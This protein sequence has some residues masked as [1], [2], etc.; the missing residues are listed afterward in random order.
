[1]PPSFKSKHPPPEPS[2]WITSALIEETTGVGVDE[3]NCLDDLEILFAPLNQAAP[4]ANDHSNGHTVGLA[5]CAR[6]RRLSLVD[7]G[8]VKLGCLQPIAH[9][10]ERLCVADQ[11]LTSL[12]DL[13]SL[14]QLRWL[15]AQQNNITRIEGLDECPRL[16]ALW[17]FDNSIQRCEG[18][19]ELAELRELWLQNNKMKRL[20]GLEALTALRDLQLA[21]NPISDYRD[22]PRLARLPS[23]ESVGFRDAHFGSCPIAEREG[24]R[25]AVLGALRHVT[26]LDASEVT[27]QDRHRARDAHLE[28]V[29]EFHEKVDALQREHRDDAAAIEARRRRSS[30]HARSLDGEMR[31]AF[32]ELERLVDEGRQA[33]K[34]E[35]AKHRRARALAQRSLDAA[36]AAA[37]AEHALACDDASHKADRR[38]RRDEC[39]LL[40]LERRAKGERR[41]ALVIAS[42]QYGGPR[43][44]GSRGDAPQ[45]LAPAKVACQLLG[46]HSPDFRWL[47]ARL[48]EAPKG[49]ADPLCLLRAYRVARRDEALPD[50]KCWF[51]RGDAALIEDAVRGDTKDGLVLYASASQACAAFRSSSNAS[52]TPQKGGDAVDLLEGSS[53]DESDDESPETLWD[54]CQEDNDALSSSDAAGSLALLLLCREVDAASGGDTATK[55]NLLMAAEASS[56]KFVGGQ[57]YKSSDL[58]ATPGGLTGVAVE[59]ILLAGSGLCSRDQRAL[60]ADLHD[61]GAVG[62]PTD[63]LLDALA[64]RVRAEVE[65]HRQRVARDLEP[66]AV[67]QLREADADLADREDQLRKTRARIQSERSAQETILRSFREPS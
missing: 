66:A 34:Q 61:D 58:L 22:L 26:S 25:D 30:A 49:D 54:E 59:H 20:G 17:L 18:L 13:G 23:L 35:H 19:T 14:P 1:M 50:G 7:C 12:K 46:E 47:D 43:F 65:G 11:K 67:D 55:R 33:V 6:L 16:R 9:T 31:L 27:R 2:P 37:L 62:G 44:T 56:Q 28:N 15:Y 10:L 52:S 53:D 38:E 36:L 51:L 5:R 57:A 63:A 24:Y 32:A 64:A 39:A 45:Q 42:L 3:H 48:R 41:I 8:L 40:A 4:S 29:L 60:E 21:G